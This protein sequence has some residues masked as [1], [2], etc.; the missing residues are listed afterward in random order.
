[1][2]T[3][4]W[5]SVEPATARR[6]LPVP[7][8]R[9]LRR[10]GLVL[11]ALGF[12]TLMASTALPWASMQ[13]NRALD[14]LGGTDN[15]NPIAQRTVSMGLDSLGSTSAL[16]YQIGLV[17]LL[18]LAGM[19]LAARP[20]QRRTLFGAAL[21]AAGGE[22]L[23]LVQLVQS[24]R[25]AGSSGSQL[26]LL[27]NSSG[28]VNATVAPGVYLAFAG[29]VLTIAAIITAAGIPGRH[30]EPAAAAAPAPADLPDQPADLTVT[31]LV[32][33]DERY[34]ARPEER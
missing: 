19:V 1:M 3:V 25:H 10:S 27:L 23:L 31:P 28:S 4:E 17:A 2:D 20:A 9:M 30:P 22:A 6:R 26:E 16:A 11:A 8:S 5:G 24:I 29:L 7:D 12:L 32:P 34:F 18:G 15:A 21:G 13:S 14:N 33:L